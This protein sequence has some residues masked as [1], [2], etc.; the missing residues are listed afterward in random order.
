MDQRGQRARVS[1]DTRGDGVI[2]ARATLKG[3]HLSAC[4][5]RLGYDW[6]REFHRV[7]FFVVVEEDK[8]FL[9]LL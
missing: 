1:F 7:V 4:L 5:E 9:I 2:K 8:R 3:A 6:V